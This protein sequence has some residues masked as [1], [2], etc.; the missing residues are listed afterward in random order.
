[1]VLNNWF[2]KGKRL[3]VGG[4]FDNNVEFYESKIHQTTK[5][6]HKK[7]VFYVVK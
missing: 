4:G 6:H 5:N 3:M 1:M 2:K 7:Q